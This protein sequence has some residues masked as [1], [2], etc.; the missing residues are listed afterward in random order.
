MKQSTNERLAELLAK[1]Q[2]TP[3]E[4]EE[5]LTLQSKRVYEPQSNDFVSKHQFAKTDIAERLKAIDWFANCGKPAVLDL[6]MPVVQV[7]SWKEAV[8]SCQEAEWENAQLE[9]RNQLSGWL[10]VHAR[11][12]FQE[13]NNRVDQHKVILASL[14]DTHWKPCFDSRNLPD[15]L[16]HTIKWD[17]LLALTE[18]S[19][20]ST[21][22]RCFF[23]HELLLVYEAGHFPCGWIGE[24]PAGKLVIY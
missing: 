24:W 22:H 21:G 8:A 11:K 18:E 12:E 20:L 14:I 23:F 10:H 2:L 3:A 7:A 5:F 4:M 16:L 6:T 15:E 9:A 13:W 17:I 1:K 19:Y